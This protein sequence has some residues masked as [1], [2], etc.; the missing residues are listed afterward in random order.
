MAYLPAVL[1]VAAGFFGT[2]YLAHDSLRPPYMHRGDPAAGYNWY[3]FTTR[4]RAKAA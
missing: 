3:E 4:A 2:N 1:L